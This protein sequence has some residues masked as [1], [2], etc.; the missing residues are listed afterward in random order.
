MGEVGHHGDTFIG[1]DRWVTELWFDRD[2]RWIGEG[3]R[4]SRGQWIQSQQDS[5]AKPPSEYG[6]L[7]GFDPGVTFFD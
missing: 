5:T 2:L 1:G 3:K 7:R 6:G 4:F